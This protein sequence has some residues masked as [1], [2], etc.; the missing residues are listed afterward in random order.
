MLGGSAACACRR[1]SQVSLRATGGAIEEPPVD[2]TQI[3]LTAS[4]PSAHS[5]QYGI[6]RGEPS[7]L[8]NAPSRAARRSAR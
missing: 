1:P 2:P 8:T 4:A 6:I 5:R 7:W 3:T